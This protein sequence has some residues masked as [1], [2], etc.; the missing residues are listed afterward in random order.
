M[1]DGGK[2]SINNFQKIMFAY[3]H[4]VKV[5]WLLAERQGS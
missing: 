5:L 4:A 1:R 3:N 2:M